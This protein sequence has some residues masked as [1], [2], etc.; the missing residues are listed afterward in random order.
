MGNSP[1]GGRMGSKQSGTTLGPGLRRPKSWRQSRECHRREGEDLPSGCHII[2]SWESYVLEHFCVLK[3]RQ[4]SLWASSSGKYFAIQTVV[5]HAIE[6][7]Q[8]TWYLKHSCFELQERVRNLIQ[9]VEGSAGGFNWPLTIF[10]IYS[11]CLHNASIA[12]WKAEMEL[13]LFPRLNDI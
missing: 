7:C 6:D 5:F 1:I 12:S 9:W 3:R 2:K 4:Y 13:K 8:I 11:G 10:S